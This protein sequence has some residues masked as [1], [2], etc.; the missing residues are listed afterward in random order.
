MRGAGVVGT[1]F[2]VLAS[3]PDAYHARR[4]GVL[5]P[6]L[7]PFVAELAPDVHRSVAHCRRPLGQGVELATFSTNSDGKSRGVGERCALPDAHTAV[8]F[9]MPALQ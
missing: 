8:G 7:T 4:N 9:L 1:M 5:S 3:T 2:L 6:V